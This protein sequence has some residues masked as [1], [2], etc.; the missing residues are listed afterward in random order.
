MQRS[1]TFA[2]SISVQHAY[3]VDVGRN[4]QE[5]CQNY[6]QFT[7]PGRRLRDE[8]RPSSCVVSDGVNW[9]YDDESPRPLLLARVTA[10]PASAR[11]L[12]ARRAASSAVSAW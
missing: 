6:S 2:S 3:T 12:H 8:T 7:S 1:P 11:P 10:L 9:L 5:V 4:V